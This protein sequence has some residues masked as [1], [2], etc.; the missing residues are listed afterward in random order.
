MISPHLRKLLL[1]VPVLMAAL[2]GRAQDESE[3]YRDLDSRDCPILDTPYRTL[4]A[5][6]IG[7]VFPA[8]ADQSGWDDLSV[9]EASAW[10]RVWTWENNVGGD[11]E[12][13]LKWDSMVLEGFSGPSGTDSAYTLTMARIFLQW[14]Q[15]YVNGYGLQLAAAPGAYTGLDDFSGDAFAC[16]AG[17]TFSKAFSP[18]LAAFLGAD[19]YPGFDVVVDPRAGLHYALRD[20]VVLQ[21]AYPESRFEVA[22]LESLRFLVGARMQRWPEYALG[23]ED[24]RE[25]LQYDETRLFAGLEWNVTARTQIALQGGYLVGRTF[26]FETGSADVE[27]DDA[28]FAMLGIRGRW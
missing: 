17:L 22:P 13:Q 1:L 20:S 19:V 2:L 18:D 12:T 9:I 14:S 7:Y 28:P 25:R 15:R 5:L 24:V 6:D 10:V 3:S 27:L 26:A 4:S 23:S 11:I 16:P 8:A 21:V